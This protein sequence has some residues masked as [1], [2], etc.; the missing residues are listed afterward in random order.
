MKK[1]FSVICV[2]PLLLLSTTLIAQTE[3]TAAAKARSSSFGTKINASDAIEATTL[4]KQM[5]GKDSLNIKVKGKVKDVCQRKGCWMNVDLGNGK[6]MMVRFKDY[7]FFVPKN[8]GGKTVVMEGVAYKTETPVE[9]LR[10]YAEDAGK[11]KEEIE[12]INQPKKN[13]SFEA[14]GVLILQ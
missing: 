13:T 8:I 12:K 4:L 11:S 7:G 6:E 2:L 14:S 5:E 9:E 1:I 3:A 10:H